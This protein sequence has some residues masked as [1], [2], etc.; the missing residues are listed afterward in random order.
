MNRCSR[1]LL[2]VLMSVTSALVCAAPPSQIRIAS[3]AW[4]G[5]T[6]GDG[7]GLAWDI[8]RAIYEPAGVQLSIQSVPYTRSIGLV[9]R[10]AADAWAGSYLNE[11][12]HGVFYPRL[13][14]DADQIVALSLLDQPIPTLGS[15]GGF[16][17]AWMRGYEFQRYLPNLQQYREVLRRDGVLSMLDAGR[18][19]FY[20]DALTEVD[21]VLSKARQPARYRTTLLTKLPI[22]LG[23]AETPRGHILAELFDKRMETLIADGS[24]RPIFQRW[25]QPYPFD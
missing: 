14:Y 6:N 7:S 9:Q 25:Q 20:L 19:D 10:G 5:R 22:Y 11:V 2:C 23:F 21:D 15:L 12:E 1:W 8:L 4:A 18:A 24:L 16:R 3:E 17:L 13:S